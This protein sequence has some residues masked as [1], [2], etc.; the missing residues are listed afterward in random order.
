MTNDD[1][2]SELA[3]LFEAAAEAGRGT[4]VVRAGDLHRA[5]GGD[6]GTNDR[7][8]LCCNVMYAEM[9][10]GDEVLSAPPGGQGASVAIAYRL[11]RPGANAD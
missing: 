2:R 1:L 4:I 9:A 7:M 6:P 3:G 11:P 10:D 5:A 8:A